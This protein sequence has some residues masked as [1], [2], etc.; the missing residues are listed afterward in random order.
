MQ[1]TI[2]QVT[3]HWTLKM[4]KIIFW[5]FRA[6]AGNLQRSDPVLKRFGPDLLTL[7][8][9]GPHPVI[10]RVS[11]LGYYL[12][13]SSTCPLAQPSSSSPLSSSTLFLEM[14]VSLRLLCLYG[15]SFRRLERRPSLLAIGCSM[16]TRYWLSFLSTANERP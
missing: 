8:G 3:R 16:K 2:C 13:P 6:T 14:R 12:S 9:V 1:S 11:L 5:D 7:F 4:C 10:S 15:P